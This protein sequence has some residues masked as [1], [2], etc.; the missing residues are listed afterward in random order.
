MDSEGLKDCIG[1]LL[2][3]LKKADSNYDKNLKF[4][5][6]EGPSHSFGLCSSY[7]SSMERGNLLRNLNLSQKSLSLRN[8]S[9]KSEKEDNCCKFCESQ[10]KNLLCDIQHLT[11]KEEIKSSE[12][13]QIIVP[14]KIL[15]KSKKAISMTIRPP[16]KKNKQK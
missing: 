7:N 3:A 14:K 12:E 1:I 4:F 10:M 6:S 8:D 13:S 5:S 9:S 16:K 15:N 2:S 11:I